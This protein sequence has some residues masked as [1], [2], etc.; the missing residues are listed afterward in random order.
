M[1]IIE[2]VV[3]FV[4]GGGFLSF[5]QWLIQRHDTRHDE[6]KDLKEYVVQMEKR[7]SEKI[8]SIESKA[9]ERNAINSRV[10]ILRFSD[11]VQ[12]GVKHSK[13]SFDQCMTDIDD[14]EEYCDAHPDFKNNQ[15]VTTVRYLKKM[16]AERLEKHDF[17]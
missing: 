15:T 2:T 5:V 10:R 12:R 8:G 6:I 16:Y 4:L 17:L 3:A 13:D 11:E 1:N 7:L 14:Y 9:D